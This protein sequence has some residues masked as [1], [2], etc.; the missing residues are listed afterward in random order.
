MSDAGFAAF[1][2]GQ[3]TARRYHDPVS[4]EEVERELTDHEEVMAMLNGGLRPTDSATYVVLG[5]H[6]VFDHE[7]G[8]EFTAAL[9]RH[10]ER[11]LTDGGFIRRLEEEQPADADAE[12]E[13]PTPPAKKQTARRSQPKEK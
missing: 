6:K 5:D 4:G 10:Q 12:Q 9:S 7:A 11:F 2:E 8:E 1:H 3:P 13:A